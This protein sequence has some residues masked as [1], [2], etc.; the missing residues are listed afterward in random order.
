[1]CGQGRGGDREE[2][3]AQGGV[4]PFLLVV[5]ALGKGPVGT[6]LRAGTNQGK[7]AR[8]GKGEGR[9]VVTSASS[10]VA[11]SLKISFP[12][13]NFHR[14]LTG[15]RMSVAEGRNKGAGLALENSFESLHPL[16]PRSPNRCPVPMRL[17]WLCAGPLPAGL[18]P[19]GWRAL[20]YLT[21]ST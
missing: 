3:Q 6:C 20:S 10:T 9:A 2:A 14:H 16:C 1:M 19:K 13:A 18:E 12:R 11:F 21:Y 15:C 8:V 5:V 17:C 7:L 4:F